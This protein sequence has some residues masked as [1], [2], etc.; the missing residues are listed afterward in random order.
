MHSKMQKLACGA[1]N[2]YYHITV[3][4]D[5]IRARFKSPDRYTLA[6]FLYPSATAHKHREKHDA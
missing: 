2:R 1:Y 3:S 6:S 5:R 4:S